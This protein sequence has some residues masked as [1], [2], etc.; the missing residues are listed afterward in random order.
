MRGEHPYRTSH[1]P[2]LR[3]PPR[4]RWLWPELFGDDWRIARRAMGGHWELWSIVLGPTTD[5]F[6]G[7]S[8][9]WVQLSRC[10]EAFKWPDIDPEAYLVTCE[11]HGPVA[12]PQDFNRRSDGWAEKIRCALEP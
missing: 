10:S 12:W 8:H 7:S 9:V 3:P 5:L 2:P 6:D 1:H 11:D 4:L